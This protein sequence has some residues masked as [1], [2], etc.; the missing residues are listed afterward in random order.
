MSEQSKI[1]ELSKLHSL[2]NYDL[3]FRTAAVMESFRARLIEAAAY[4]ETNNAIKA[5]SSLNR[6][7]QENENDQYHLLKGIAL[8]KV[9]LLEDS[10]HHLSLVTQDSKELFQTRLENSIQTRDMGFLGNVLNDGD[11]SR[12]G[13]LNKLRIFSITGDYTNLLKHSEICVKKHPQAPMGWGYLVER[14]DLS[15]SEYRELIAFSEKSKDKAEAILF[16]NVIG[17]YFLKKND[18][19]NGTKKIVESCAISAK[20][21]PYD[22]NYQE[23]QYALIRSLNVDVTPKEEQVLQPI[24]IVGMPRSGST[25]LEKRFLDAGYDSVGESLLFSNLVQL[26]LAKSGKL[27]GDLIRKSYIR[28]IAYRGIRSNYWIDKSLNNFKYMSV[29]K[30]VFPKAKFLILNRDTKANF[31]SIYKTVFK[32]GNLFSNDFGWIKKEYDL[33]RRFISEQNVDTAF[34]VR[35]EDVVSGRFQIAPVGKSISRPL[36]TASS[37][38]VYKKTIS[39]RNEEIQSVEPVLKSLGI[40]VS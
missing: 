2:R 6:I 22:L 9:S 37:H 8:S 30:S 18:Y 3:L 29:I 15:K 16:A 13:Y 24:F 1:K 25:L 12:S 26:S 21:S 19:I 39:N 28:N 23:K 7:S 33:M 40:Q 4:L 27:D 32:Q 14:R 36:A 34:T 10:D 35:Y 20:E 17:K 11:Y 5:I 31:W 38:I